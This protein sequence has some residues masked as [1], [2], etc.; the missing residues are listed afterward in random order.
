V[1][2]D[3]LKQLTPLTSVLSLRTGSGVQLVDG[4]VGQGMGIVQDG[5]FMYIW[6]EV[7]RWPTRHDQI[8][9]LTYSW[10]FNRFIILFIPTTYLAEEN[11]RS[12]QWVESQWKNVKTITDLI[13]E[14]KEIDPE[15]ASHNKVSYFTPQ[16]LL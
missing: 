7:G 10:D 12:Q 9:T 11:N 8:A 1:V 15:E 5:H 16:L 13:V 6:E 4:R 2:E 3:Y 14:L